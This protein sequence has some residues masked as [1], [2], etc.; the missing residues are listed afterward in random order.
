MSINQKG[1]KFNAK[2]VKR[3]FCPT[4]NYTYKIKIEEME[5]ATYTCGYTSDM[6]KLEESIKVLIRYVIM[7]YK[8]RL[9]IFKLI[10]NAKLPYI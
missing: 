3:N 2:I 10:I 6:D 7:K 1:Y 5:G 4:S 9:C 8:A